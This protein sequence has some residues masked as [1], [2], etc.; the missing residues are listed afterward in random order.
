LSPS[1][2][3]GGGAS[4]SHGALLARGAFFNTL[5]F[6]ASNLRGIFTFLVAR[7][8][9]SAALGLFGLAWAT[10]DLVS[11]IGTLGL[12]TGAI[13]FVA[14]SEAAGAR[15]ASRQIRRAS[16]TLALTASSV[17][18]IAGFAA[19][20]W[21][22]AHGGQRAPLAR[23]T[24]VM[25]LALP[26]IALYRISNALS[27]GMSV[28]HHDIYSRGL[29]ES[30]GT[31]AALLAALALGAR[32]LAPELAG[33]A[34]TLLSGIVAFVCARSLYIARDGGVFSGKADIAL[35]VR[36][37]LPVAL[38]DLLNIGI[39]Q[40]DLIMLGLFVGRA[41]GVTLETLGIYAAACEVAGGLRKVNQ[42]FNPIFV[43]VV[44]QQIGDGRMRD[45]EATYGYL[46]RWMLAV[47]LPAV[48]V[49]ALA[50]GAIMR[51][52]GPTFARGGAWTA[53]V[54]GACALNAFVAL[55]E[56]ILVVER[57]NLNLLNSSI[58]CAAAIGVNLALIPR[59]GALGAAIGMLV[60]Y[61]IQGL[62]RGM[63]ISHV[64][65][66]RWPWRALS[67]PWTAALAALV[68]A[69][70][71]R[72][73]LGSGMLPQLLSAAAYLGA[74]VLAWAAIGLD[75]H[76]RD[77]LAHLFEKRRRRADALSAEAS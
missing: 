34:G 17:L 76:D 37:S 51:I 48:A 41:S 18:A 10:T 24:A 55:G 69:L 65:E 73:A 8:I 42:A 22:A 7:L 56:T 27:R 49:L 40:I 19:A 23:A 63:E 77:V 67:K 3:A 2:E 26:G 28:M 30:L 47:L 33:I 20:S 43:P 57:P 74:Y 71:I 53:I 5:A 36:R 60:P 54:G 32:E 68:P 21:V 35:L 13:T 62:L 39:M 4:A 58:A 38:Y 66:W 25:L 70:A 16:L 9:G 15:S 61:S 72:Y 50:G 12:D 11:K 46:A 6:L 45:A 75:P 14:R 52:Y 64:F 59:L 1:H 44:A 29:T 31:A